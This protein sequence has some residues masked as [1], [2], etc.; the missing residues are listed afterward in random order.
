MGNDIRIKALRNRPP[1]SGFRKC[2][3]NR[4]YYF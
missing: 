2:C 4:I 3:G 1:T